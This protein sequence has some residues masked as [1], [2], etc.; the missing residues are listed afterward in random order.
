VVRGSNGDW[1][2]SVASNYVFTKGV[3]AMCCGDDEFFVITAENTLL[4]VTI[5]GEMKQLGTVKGDG[6]FVPQTREEAG[7]CWTYC[8]PRCCRCYQVYCVC[9]TYVTWFCC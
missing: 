4:N 7:C 3:K 2:D 1:K 9:V 8:R 6:Q 5:K